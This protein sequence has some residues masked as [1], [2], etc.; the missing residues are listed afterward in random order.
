MLCAQNA[1]SNEQNPIIK[2]LLQLPLFAWGHLPDSGPLRYVH[3]SS[4]LR[5]WRSQ[6]P[7]SRYGLKVEVWR[8]YTEYYRLNTEGVKRRSDGKYFCSSMLQ[9]WHT[10]VAEARAPPLSDCQTQ[11]G[12]NFDFGPY[13]GIYRA[14]CLT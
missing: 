9:M 5:S 2:Q 8:L 10:F 13:I 7:P 6:H 4:F 11:C 12:L 3:Y 1:K 14:N